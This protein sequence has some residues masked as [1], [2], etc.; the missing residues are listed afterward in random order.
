MNIPIEFEKIMAHLRLAAIST[1]PDN[2]VIG[3]KCALKLH[4]LNMSTKPSDLDIIVYAPSQAQY[5]ILNSLR[6]VNTIED[7]PS[8]AIE[9][10]YDGVQSVKVIKIELADGSKMDIIKESEY[11]P[12][13]T[14]NL[15]R[16]TSK[17]TSWPIQSIRRVIEAKASYSF[18]HGKK[19]GEG[20]TEAEL[21]K[22]MRAKDLIDFLDLK[23]LNFNV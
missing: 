18:S 2:V 21:V 19:I 9:T 13:G 7:R 5:N 1:N 23:N 17:K 10:D 8:R 15:L 16:M 12:D 11:H 22:Y 3:G 14:E 20:E 4:G 6:E